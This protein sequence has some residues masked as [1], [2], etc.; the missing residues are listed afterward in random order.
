MRYL[1]SFSI[2]VWL[3]LGLILTAVFAPAFTC[4]AQS[5]RTEDFNGNWFFKLSYEDQLTESASEDQGWRA[6]H[7]PHDWSVEEAFDTL[8]LEGA[9]GYL[10]GGIGWYKKTLRSPES[11][12]TKTYILFDGVYNHSNT[13]INGKLLGYHPY[14][15]SPFYYDLSPH[16]KPGGKENTITVKVDRTRYADSRWYPGSGIYRNV[17]LIQTGKLHI[18]VWGVF[19]SSPEVSADAAT[20]GI[21][22]DLTNEYA[23]AKEA[24]LQATIIDAHGT[25]VAQAA[26][27]VAI[28]AGDQLSLNQEMKLANPRIWQLDRPELYT[29]KLQL[30]LGDRVEDVYSTR[31]GIRTFRFDADEGFF[32]NGK[33]TKIKGVCLH[34]DG[35]TVGA[36]VPKDLWRRR[37]AKLKEAGCNA[38]RIAHNP[39]AEELL[40]LCDEMGF[41]VQDEFFDEWDYPKDKR[42]NMDEQ[43]DDAISRGSSEYFHEFGEADLKATILAH[44]NHASIFQW[45]IG[46]EIEWTYPR[47]KLSTGF[48][49]ADAGGNY[50]W[51][52]T[53][54]SPEQIKARY[55]S[56]PAPA[57]T[58][59]ATAQQLA[60]WTRSLDTTRVVVA[61]CILPSASYISGYADALDVIGFSYRRVMYDYG[62][63]HFPD[64]PILGTEN[65]PQWHEWK[66]VMERP[67]VA[68]VFLWTGVDYMGESHHREGSTARRSRGVKS[69]LLD[70][71]GFE[72]R[73]YYMMKS[74]WTD[75]PTLSIS[76][77]LLSKTAFRYDTDSHEVE[78]K[79]KGAWEKSIWY[80][81]ETNEH[82]NYQKGDSIVVEAISNMEQ[83]ELLLNGHSYGVKELEAFPDRIYKWLVPYQEGELIVRGSRA[84]E[85]VQSS[86]LSAGPANAIQL[87]ADQKYL[88]ADGYELSHIIAKIYDAQ[89]RPVRYEEEE[90]TIELSGPARVLGLDNGSPYNFRSKNSKSLLT[91]NGR[92]LIILQSLKGQ[93]GTVQ[94]KVS[95]KGYSNTITLYCQ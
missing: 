83:L 94:L 22:I 86:L 14:G 69:G 28:A 4:H 34:H 85:L 17:K 38:I 23:E 35:G 50:F 67:F 25:K 11:S 2:S 65:L 78:E 7:L 29:L 41:L 19:V 81:P 64:L 18:P 57:Y 70:Y 92:A 59:G 63:E 20:L 91:E 71:A 87:E 60:A 76:S 30:M 46:N 49:D 55:D 27:P 61:N 12:D 31:F 36:A 84:G 74:L 88:E 68:G 66:A 9:T 89:G 75:A 42:W 56:L 73:S 93:R 52:P 15:Y 6:V 5:S 54:L 16:L 10:P 51:N 8:N 40:E 62:H 21:S 90:L 53:R 79:V 26:Y 24:S 39:G 33:N 48:W 13:Y 77:Q 47:N 43:H 82:W 58:I 3:G 32:L 45:S 72:K 37:L 44:R 1:S 80:W 95:A